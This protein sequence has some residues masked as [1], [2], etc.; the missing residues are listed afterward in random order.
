MPAHQGNGHARDKLH[1]KD[2]DL[3]IVDIYN[4][5]VWSDVLAALFLFFFNNFFC[6]FFFVSSLFL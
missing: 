1:F 6:C 4:G 5:S 3:F 2:N